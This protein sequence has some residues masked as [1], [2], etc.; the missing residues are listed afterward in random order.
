MRRARQQADLKIRVPHIPLDELTVC[1]WSDAAFANSSELKTQGG[2]LICFTSDKMRQAVDVPVHC[3]SWKSYRM[4]RVVASTMSGE[5]QAFSTASGV[6]EWMLLML[7]E[8]L[9]G[10]FD[11]ESAQDV[12]NKRSPIGITDCR[13]L[14]DHLTSL[15]SGGVL[16]DK[17]T[18]IDIAIIRQCI[19]RT[20]LRLEPRWCPTTHMA[21]DALTPRSCRASRF[22]KINSP[23]LP[24]PASGRASHD[25]SKDVPRKIEG[26]VWLRVEKAEKQK[27]EKAEG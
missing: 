12:L 8:C 9:D 2:W 26:V 6:C 18:A 17:R 20:R 15:G 14:Y 23:Q 5:A 16:D 1:F 7:S 3:F 27:V 24:L 13:S 25:G 4:P 22:A 19:Q 21:A 11:L 10:P